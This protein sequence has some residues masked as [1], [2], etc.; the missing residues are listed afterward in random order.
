MDRW[1][2]GL[3][4]AAL[5]ASVGLTTAAVVVIPGSA[6]HAA[7]PYWFE[8]SGPLAQGG[9]VAVD[10]ALSSREL[11]L[12]EPL[13]VTWRLGEPQSPLGVPNPNDPNLDQGAHLA[14]TGR[15]GVHDLWT[16]G[17]TIDATGTRVV[18]AARLRDDK[19]LEFGT[20]N[21]GRVV[22][23]KVGTGT[24]S[25]GSLILDLAPVESTYNDM[26]TSVGDFSANYPG[27][28]SPSTD[29]SGLG[30]YN[31]DVQESTTDGDKAEFTFVGT[32]VDLITDRHVDM[33]KMELVVDD[34]NRPVTEVQTLDA[35]QAPEVPRKVQQKF[36]VASDLPYGKY[37]LTVTNKTQDKH[38]RIDAFRVRAGTANNHAVSPYRT[39]CEPT[40]TLP[41][42]QITVKGPD[43]TP[44]PT[45]P[46]TPTP[47]PTKTPTPTPTGTGT[48]PPSGAAAPVPWGTHTSVSVYSSSTPRPT[49]TVT[50]TVTARPQVTVTPK[51]G[52]DT[53]E[54]HGG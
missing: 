8:C 12:G 41:K 21:T 14:V 27:T 38:A 45:P 37:R 28:W 48:K 39:V 43:S 10:I 47:R 6:S 33:G 18:D 24:V 2:T 40:G 46:A 23:D 22:A 30:H 9:K 36:T 19:P 31:G 13:Q 5:A 1:G 29:S 52:A 15:V 7:G 20:L 11:S 16:G 54:G 49:T 53:G 25:V 50:A 51:G 34:L 32:G 44:T 26:F 3:R 17:G 4:R 42:I 35:Y